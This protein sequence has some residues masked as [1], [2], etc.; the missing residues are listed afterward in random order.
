MPAAVQRAARAGD[1]ELWTI[2]EVA[3]RWKMHYETV[4]RWCEKGAIVTRRVSP[5]RA[6][7]IPWSE[8]QRQEQSPL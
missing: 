3:V 2:A 4:R 7:R 1:E 5:R 8:V 6:I